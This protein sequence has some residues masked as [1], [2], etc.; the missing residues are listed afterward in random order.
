[1]L[2]ALKKSKQDVNRIDLL[3]N[4]AQFYILK[5]GESEA[6]FDSARVNIN[7]AKVLNRSLKSS[8]AD[9]YQLLTESYLTKENG[10]RDEARKM[11]ERAVTIFESGTNKSYL[12]SAYYELASYYD[13]YDD[14]QLPREN[15]L[16]R[17][18]NR[19]IST[20]WE[21]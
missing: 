16:G 2:T 5:P 15:T 4:L 20:S 1:M 18:I 17:G 13:H 10:Q 14:L 3:L 6:D 9:G 19:T 12:G 7:E 8:A 11:V 21:Y